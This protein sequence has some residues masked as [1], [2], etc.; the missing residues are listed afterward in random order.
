MPAHSVGLYHRAHDKKFTSPDI[1]S[2]INK[3]SS[4]KPD[5]ST[6]INY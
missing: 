5:I 1:M 2:E 3:V 4:D 6:D